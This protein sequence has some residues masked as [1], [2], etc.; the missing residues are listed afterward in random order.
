MGDAVFQYVAAAAATQPVGI[1]VAA[2]A[3]QTTV[4]DDIAAAGD[5]DTTIILN[6]PFVIEQ[7]SATVEVGQSFVLMQFKNSPLIERVLLQLSLDRLAFM[8]L[9]LPQWSAVPVA[10]GKPVQPETT[11]SDSQFQ[12]ASQGERDAINEIDAAP[13][14]QTRTLLRDPLIQYIRSPTVRVDEIVVFV[15]FPNT[16]NAFRVYVG[17]TLDFMQFVQHFILPLAT[18]VAIGENV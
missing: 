1:F 6:R 3:G 12:A 15:N 9:V 10:L 2:D 11:W 18:A 5:V 14:V 13:D 4:M 7:V 16:T 8:Q 17:S